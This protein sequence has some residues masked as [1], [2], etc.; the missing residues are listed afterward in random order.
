[1][2]SVDISVS[3]CRDATRMGYD[4]RQINRIV[5]RMAQYFLD[6]NMRVI[7]GHDWHEDGVMRAIADFAEVVAAGNET[8]D[9]GLNDAAVNRDLEH[10]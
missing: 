7:F 1:M 8:R 5:I 3:P 4:E 2:W 6:R 10:G 9:E